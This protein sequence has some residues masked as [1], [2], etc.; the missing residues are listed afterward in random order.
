VR[1]GH[2]SPSPLRE[3]RPSERRRFIRRSAGIAKGT[4]PGHPVVA[5]LVAL[6]GNSLRSLLAPSALP[7]RHHRRALTAAD[8]GHQLGF[9]QIAGGV[10]TVSAGNRIALPG[11]VT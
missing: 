9:G 1:I 4:L 10:G 2:W 5:I 3:G 7:G 11:L 8:V 6:E